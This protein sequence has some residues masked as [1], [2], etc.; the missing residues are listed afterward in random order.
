MTL[1]LTELSALRPLGEGP[2]T[3]ALIAPAGAVLP[4]RIEAT[5]V[6]LEQMGYIPRLMDNARARHRYLAGTVEQRLADFHAAFH[7][8]DVAAVWCLRGGYGCAQLIDHI[9]W[10]RLPNVP[11]IGYSDISVLL[12]AFHAHDRR[13]I[14]APVATELALLEQANGAEAEAR[15]A[16]M[17]SIAPAL[18]GDGGHMNAT[19]VAGPAVDLSG[20]LIGG[21]LTTLASVAGTSGALHVPEDAIVMLEDVGERLY[22]LER[23]LCQLLDSLE[24]GR[25]N[26]VCLGSF[27]DCD[28]GDSSVEAMMQEWLAPH[29]I[30]LYHRLPFG[31]GAHN[32]AWPVGSMARL[33]SDGLEWRAR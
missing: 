1:S 20:P 26:A 15:S 28:T 19:H 4:E 14:H 8:P 21:N 18:R 24:P 6:L 33:S 32:Q 29:D 22:R 23:S 13:T 25:L 31:H 10:A 3:V 2:H 30:A 27:T 12:S 7:L 5:C 11:L 17:A 9:D 16:A